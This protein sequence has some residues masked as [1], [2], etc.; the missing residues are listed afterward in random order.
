MEGPGAGDSRPFTI[1]KY[2]AMETAK[3]KGQTII[4]GIAIKP[5]VN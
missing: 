4:K 5:P 3:F 2:G 1:A